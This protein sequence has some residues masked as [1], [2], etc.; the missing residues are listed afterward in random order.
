MFR[1]NKYFGES[2]ESCF[3]IFAYGFPD[4]FRFISATN[5]RDKYVALSTIVEPGFVCSD[6]EKQLAR[7][8]KEIRGEVTCLHLIHYKFF[9]TY[10]QAR[11]VFLQISIMV[12]IRLVQ[13]RTLFKDI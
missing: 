10:N 11:E 13:C 4:C 8:R 9:S 3:E 7:E 5:F 6:W 12:F 1:K 2:Y